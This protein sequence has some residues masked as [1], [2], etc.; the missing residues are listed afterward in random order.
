MNAT[1][2]GYSQLSARLSNAEILRL[3]KEGRLEDKIFRMPPGEELPFVICVGKEWRAEGLPSDKTY[4]EKKSYMVRI[5]CE[6]LDALQQ[7]RSIG[8]NLIVVKLRE[9]YIYSEDTSPTYF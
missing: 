7:G 4:D 1:I 6:C 3:K 8:T 9:V 5:P 2:D